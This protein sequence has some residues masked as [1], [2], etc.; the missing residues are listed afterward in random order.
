[1]TQG[2]GHGKLGI[3][4]KASNNFDFLNTYFSLYNNKILK[5]C[6][7]N[8]RIQCVCPDHVLDREGPFKGKIAN[9]DYWYR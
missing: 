8:F 6:V 3:E 7:M 9:V 4:L 5:N 1:M 2:Q